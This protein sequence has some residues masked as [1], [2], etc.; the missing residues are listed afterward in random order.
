MNQKN[1]IFEKV[2][3]LRVFFGTMFAR[4]LPKLPPP[5]KMGGETR[6]PI[7][8]KKTSWP[9]FLETSRALLIHEFLMEFCFWAALDIF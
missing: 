3:K 6:K 1:T 4:D 2:S 7:I 5:Q 9:R 8:Y